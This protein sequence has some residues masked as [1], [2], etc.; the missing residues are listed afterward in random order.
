[1]HKCEGYLNH[2]KNDPAI[3]ECYE[4]QDGTLWA[5]DIDFL[6]QVNFC[7]YCGYKAKIPAIIYQPERLNPENHIGDNTNMIC[8]SLTS[9]VTMR[10]DVEE[11]PRCAEQS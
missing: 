10:G 3:E 7:P 9:W 11:L 8:E 6:S 5:G 4:L 2:G 1:M